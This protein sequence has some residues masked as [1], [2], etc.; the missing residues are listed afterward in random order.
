VGRKVGGLSVRMH[1]RV[2]HAFE[3]SNGHRHATD[4]SP[5]VHNKLRA[6]RHCTTSSAA[7]QLGTS[8][9][10]KKFDLLRFQLALRACPLVT[11]S[12]SLS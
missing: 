7:N 10:E 12:G 2:I 6:L 3:S 9:A 4:E 8:C 11:K 1:L 5:V